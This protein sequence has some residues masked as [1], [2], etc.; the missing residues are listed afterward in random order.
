MN[1]TTMNQNKSR[2]W[3]RARRR[4][5][6]PRQARPQGSQ[7]HRTGWIAQLGHT[8]CSVGSGGFQHACGICSGKKDSLS[9]NSLGDTK[10]S[11]EK[12]A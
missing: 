4:W 8:V 2:K 5:H 12:F 6:D 10:F 9:R 11:D 3:F 1:T 7:F